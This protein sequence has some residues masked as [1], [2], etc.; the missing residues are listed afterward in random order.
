MRFSISSRPVFLSV[1]TFALTAYAHAQGPQ[2]TVSVDDRVYVVNGGAVKGKNGDEPLDDSIVE[3]ARFSSRV[4]DE[5]ILHS[6]YNKVH[7]GALS[8]SIVYADSFSERLIEPWRWSIISA[9][10]L[11]DGSRQGAGTR[12]FEEAKKQFMAWSAELAA[13]PSQLTLAIVR[14]D[15]LNGIS[16]YKENAVIFR[17]VTRKNEILSYSDAV[18]FLQNQPKSLQLAYAR[19]LEES[20]TAKEVSAL[21][22]RG[23]GKSSAALNDKLRAIEKSAFQDGPG[24]NGAGAGT[25]ANDRQNP[26]QQRLASEGALRA[27]DA[28]SPAD[29]DEKFNGMRKAAESDPGNTV[30]QDYTEKSDNVRKGFQRQAEEFRREPPAPENRPSPPDSLWSPPPLQQV[31]R[32][33]YDTNRRQTLRRSAAGYLQQRTQPR[34]Y[35]S[36]SGSDKRTRESDVTGGKNDP[37]RNETRVS[38]NY[39]PP[40]RT[41]AEIVVKK[42]KTIPGG[43]TLEGN[44]PELLPIKRAVYVPQANAIILNDD[45]FYLI[46]VTANECAE[47]FRALAIDDNMGIS[48]TGSASLT[49]GSLSPDGDVAGNLKLTDKFLGNIAFGNRVLMNSYA[50]AP[51]YAGRRPRVTAPLAVYFNFQD[52]RFSET[53]A[54]ELV[55]SDAK[56][57]ATLIPLVAKKSDDGGHLPDLDRID[58][59]DVPAE[60]VDNLRSLQENIAYYAQERIVRTAFAY[61]EIASFARSLKASG[62]DLSTQIK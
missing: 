59:G 19:A 35:S 17:K 34:M 43:V 41:S 56:L 48:L 44:S 23:S 3:K 31:S 51:G 18:R 60:Y 42:Y 55:R 39:R 45:V 25:S 27:D 47:I 14:N 4:L 50:F 7:Y 11:S 54:G 6:D 22:Q 38:A 2:L 21:E 9:P 46:P 32:R 1:L 15:Y 58:K 61:G 12:S 10:L 26:A 5:H 24:G 40:T 20:L 29:L 53:D 52:F 36:I 49:Y 8:R 37:K 62:I 13:N 28:K 33:S 57:N 16:A 30:L